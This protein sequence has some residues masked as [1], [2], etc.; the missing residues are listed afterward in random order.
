M[1]TKIEQIKEELKKVT[2]ELDLYRNAIKPLQMRKTALQKKLWVYEMREK[3]K[4]V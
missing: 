3:Q 4:K 1:N 2:D